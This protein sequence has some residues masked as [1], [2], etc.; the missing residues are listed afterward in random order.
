MYVYVH[1]RK[2]RI[3]RWSIRI[4]GKLGK[5]RKKGGGIE[6]GCSFSFS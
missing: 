1:I 6:M 5:E 2:R 3:Y 4:D